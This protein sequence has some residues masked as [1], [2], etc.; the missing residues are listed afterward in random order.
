MIISPVS[1]SISSASSEAIAEYFCIMSSHVD[2]SFC[3][4]A[5]LSAANVDSE[6]DDD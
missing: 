1:R 3:L 2:W 4:E 6:G 5:C